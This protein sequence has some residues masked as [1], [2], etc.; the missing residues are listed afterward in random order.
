MAGFADA[1]KPEK[2]SGVHFK[3]WQVKITL[4]LTAMNFFW[5][6]KGKPEGE[7]SD[8]D[9]KKFSEAT[10]VFLGYIFSVLADRLYDVYMHMKDAKVLWDALNAKF[11]ASYAGSE[12]YVMENFHDKTIEDN[13][14]VVEQA[15]EIQCIVKELELLKCPLPDKFVAGCIIAKLPSLWSSF[16]TTLKHKR[17][18]ISVKNLIASLDVEEKARAKDAHG[19]RTEGQSSANIVQKNPHG[20]NKGKTKPTK[21]ISFKK[22]RKKTNKDEMPCYSC[23]EIGHFARDCPSRGDL[24]KKKANPRQ[25]SKDVNMVT[26]DTTGGDG[27]GNLST[28]LSIS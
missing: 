10:T 8:D 23:G 19:K 4:W 24:R 1:L 21:T 28:V 3:R 11:S 7:L 18:E 17:Q 15:H 12:L 6:G 25:G 5:V 9:Q 26:M 20:K 27:Y 2:F 16:A 13:R 14:S 22:K